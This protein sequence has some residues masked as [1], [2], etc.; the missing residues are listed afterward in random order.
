MPTIIKLLIHRGTQLQFFLDSS[1]SA[2]RTV[3]ALCAGFCLATLLAFTSRAAALTYKA[4]LL[5]PAQLDESTGVGA[6]GSNQVGYGSAKQTIFKAAETVS[7]SKIV[8]PR[9][10]PW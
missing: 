5:Q 10:D 2:C 8:V 7:S 1:A 9:H 4:V 3:R 6:S